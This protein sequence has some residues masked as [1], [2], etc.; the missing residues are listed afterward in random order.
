V[1]SRG[2]GSP[3]AAPAGAS[4]GVAGR[5]QRAAHAFERGHQ[6]VAPERLEQVVHRAER[7][8]RHRV[9]IV[10]GREHHRRPVRGALQGLQP[11]ALGQ[12]HV[13]Q[14]ERGV[15]RVQRGGG[16]RPVRRHADDV[17]PRHLA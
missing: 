6:P 7:E 1:R 13:E 17:D 3:A 8:R 11:G 2:G 12:L 14:D 9:P 10:R 4:A 16:R 15:E 5:G